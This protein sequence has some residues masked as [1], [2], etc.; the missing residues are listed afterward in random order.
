[1]PTPSPILEVTRPHV[2]LER[3]DHS[4]VGVCPFCQP[5]RGTR[6]FH[7][8]VDRG[9]FFCFGCQEGGNA[10]T[11]LRRLLSTRGPVVLGEASCREPSGARYPCS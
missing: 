10:E 11:F 5:E 1:M 8:N 7:V 4:H 2:Q 9:F 6:Q 3:R